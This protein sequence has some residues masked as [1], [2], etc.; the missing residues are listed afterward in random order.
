[1]HVLCRFNLVRVSRGEQK[2]HREQ[3]II[4][5]SLH[6]SLWYHTL[7]SYGLY[8]AKH[9]ECDKNFLYFTSSTR[10]LL[11]IK[12]EEL[13]ELLSFSCRVVIAL[14]TPKIH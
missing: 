14:I 3:R 9:I 10:N 6:G 1:M 4:E 12:W 7:M 2:S 5:A 13:Y 11:A 8:G